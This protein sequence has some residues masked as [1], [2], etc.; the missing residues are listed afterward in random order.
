MAS[1]ED[2][3]EF[4]FDLSSMLGMSSVLNK[5]ET[6]NSINLKALEKDLFKKETFGFEDDEDDYDNSD[7]NNQEESMVYDPVKEYNDIINSD[8]RDI[9][10][11]STNVNEIREYSYINTDESPESNSYEDKLTDEQTSQNIINSYFVS[12]NDDSKDNYPTE[13][14]KLNKTGGA[15]ISNYVNTWNYDLDQENREDMKLRLLEKIDNLKEELE[16]DGINLDK[17]PVVDFSSKL[18][19]IENTAKLLM[20]KATRNRYSNMGEEFILAISNGLEILCNGKREFFGVRPD[21]TNCTDIVKV[22]LRRVKNETS[23]IVADVVE[24][25]EIPPLFTV[26][27]ELVP[28]LFLHSQRRSRQK[29]IGMGVF[30]SNDDIDLSDDINEIRKYN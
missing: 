23:Q 18:E 4:D 28:A 8:G 27:I 30:N 5:E 11:N 21:L 20:L 25:Y 6:D 29:K 10:T 9:S 3:S 15:N 26:L 17:I 1:F 22:K 13:T 24:K 14:N 12:S 7:F 16:D 19:E 2:D